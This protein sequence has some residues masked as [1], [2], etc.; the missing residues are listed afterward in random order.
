MQIDSGKKS[1]LQR[2]SMLVPN[3]LKQDKTNVIALNKGEQL[4][5]VLEGM[6]VI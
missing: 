2:G 4:S 1:Q 5:M 3:I 6:S